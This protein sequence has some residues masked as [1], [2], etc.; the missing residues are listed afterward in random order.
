[1]LPADAQLESLRAKTA[2]LFDP[3]FCRLPTWYFVSRSSSRYLSHKSLEQNRL[4][5]ILTHSGIFETKMT[6]AIG[7]EWS[8]MDA[9]NV[10]FPALLDMTIS[11][12]AD[13]VRWKHQVDSRGAGGSLV[14]QR[15]GQV[16][17]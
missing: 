5:I 9:C 17:T 12:R 11:C 7:F 3:K 2:N 13:K 14:E 1:L 8:S 10:I 6:A 4:K 16:N 15:Y